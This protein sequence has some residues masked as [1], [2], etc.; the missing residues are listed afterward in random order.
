MNQSSIDQHGSPI[1]VGDRVKVVKIPT[2]L[3]QGLPEEDQIAIYSQ[4]GKTLIIQ[5]F[6]EDNNAELEFTDNDGHIHTI[7]IKPDCLEKM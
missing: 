6:N 2:R 4:I 1:V 7:W 5:G 3:P